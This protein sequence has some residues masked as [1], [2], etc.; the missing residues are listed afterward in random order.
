MYEKI[1][2]KAHSLLSYRLLQIYR[3]IYSPFTR[4][5]K[6]RV[7][8]CSIPLPYA[9]RSVS[10]FIP[11]SRAKVFHCAASPNSPATYCTST[12][13]SA[14]ESPTG[15]QCASTNPAPS[16]RSRSRSA[17]SVANSGG[18]FSEE[19]K[20]LKELSFEELEE[21]EGVKGVRAE[22]LG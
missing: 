2:E 16:S 10:G 17:R 15:C 7:F 13:F 20:E 22:C 14:S 12:P 8:F 19:L 6:A 21:L 11:H 5:Q 9:L 18:M 4:S 1:D 3:S